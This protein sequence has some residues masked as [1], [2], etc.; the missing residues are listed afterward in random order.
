MKKAILLLICILNILGGDAFAGNLQ[1]KNKV[2]STTILQ[3]VYENGKPITYKESTETFNKQGKT[4]MV[5]EYDKD[6]TIIRKETT[7][8]DKDQNVIEET[9]FCLKTNKNYKKT[10]KYTVIKDKTPLA[11]EVEYNA[12]GAVIKRI[13]YTYNANGNKASEMVTDANGQLI[14]KVVFLYNSK[15]L[16]TFKQTYNKDNAFESIKEWQYEYY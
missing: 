15:N 16:K 12:S 5:I 4:T 10:Y 11:E 7:N 8:Y 14:N 13:S 1:K 6:G 9:F 3:T 2:K